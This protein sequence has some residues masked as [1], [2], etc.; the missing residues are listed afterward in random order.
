MASP[1]ATL[2]LDEFMPYL[3]NVLAARLSADL[4]AIYE[5]RFGITIPEWRVIAHLAGNQRVSIREIYARVGMDKVKVSRAA[6]SLEAAGLVS[7]T[8][9][10]ADRRLVSLEL[11]VKGQS[12]YAAIVPLALEFQTA[13]LSAL[14][15]DER[16]E[17]Q[18][19]VH[20]LLAS[21]GERTAPEA[22]ATA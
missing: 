15:A 6:G 2:K 10:P 18:R 11:T 16:A 5:T 17:F 13:S 19:L 12:V 9:N 8:V 14:T 1:T 3:V 7:K 22:D 4:A 21:M 20:K